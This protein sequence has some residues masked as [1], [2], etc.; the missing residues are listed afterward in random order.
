MLL[1]GFVIETYSRE[2]Q[3]YFYFK[4]IPKS[5]KKGENWVKKGYI[6]ISLWRQ[7]S[8]KK[9]TRLFVKIV[10]FLQVALSEQVLTEE[11]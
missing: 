3:S 11:K 5:R 2:T 1:A 8:V 7:I 10:K 4:T 6:F 9:V